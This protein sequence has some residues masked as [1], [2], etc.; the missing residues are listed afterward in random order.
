[1]D[2]NV[3]LHRDSLLLGRTARA[4]HNNL[5]PRG[6]FSP[7]YAVAGETLESGH[8]EGGIET[9]VA[10]PMPP[11]GRLHAEDDAADEPERRKKSKRSRRDNGKQRRTEVKR[12]AREEWEE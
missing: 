6:W 11:Y 7:A 5:G 3:G 10:H 2:V 12:R 4:R 1:M 9:E 8:A